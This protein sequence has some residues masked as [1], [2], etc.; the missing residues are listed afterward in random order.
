MSLFNFGI[1]TDAGNRGILQPKLKYKF[2]VVF[3]NFGGAGEGRAFTQNVVS[4]DR[5]KLAYS[6]VPIHSYNSIAYAMGKHEWSTMTCAIRD[7]VTN[8]VVK[9]TG[10]QVQRQV[11]HHNQTSALSGNDFKFGMRID[12]MTGAAN[13]ILEQWTLEG[14][15]LQNVDYD[16]G[17]YSASEPLVVTLTVRFDNAIQFGAGENDPA[18]STIFSGTPAQTGGRT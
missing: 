3:F 6:E 18:S 5:P 17:D 2:R 9:L 14:C 16:G 15:F 10:R 8:E 12:I 1:N 13:A 7:D 4:V 11:D